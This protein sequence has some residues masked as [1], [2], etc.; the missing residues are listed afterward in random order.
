MLL[1]KCQEVYPW[2][3]NTAEAP[4][5]QDNVQTSKKQAC[6]PFPLASFQLKEDHSQTA[7]TIA[8]E[9]AGKKKKAEW[10]KPQSP[11]PILYTLKQK[12]KP[13][14]HLHFIFTIT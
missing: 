12:P 13:K 5:Q 10:S 11:T 2:F 14:R 3:I 1:K 6:Q 4:K 8:S 9:T 7:A